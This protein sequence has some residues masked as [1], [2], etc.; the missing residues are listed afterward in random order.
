MRHRRQFGDTEQ[1]IDTFKHRIAQLNAQRDR[2]PE[3]AGSARFGRRTQELCTAGLPEAIAKQCAAANDIAVALPI[4]DAADGA[5]AELLAVAQAYVELGQSLRLGWLREQLG[6][7]TANS[8]WQA[9]ER[10]SLLDDVATHQSRLAAAAVSHADGDIDQWMRSN[11]IFTQSWQRTIENIEH[12]GA[13][14]FSLY[15][16]T[17]R[18]LDDLCRGLVQG[19]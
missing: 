12:A 19:S 18:K 16:M 8:H 7:M 2:F 6:D 4:I 11:Q 14:D 1:F 9:M 15:S 10:D 13:P 5:N 17:G 3:T